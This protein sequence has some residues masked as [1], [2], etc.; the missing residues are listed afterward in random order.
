MDYGRACARPPEQ[1]AQPA[2][3]RR[4]AS[5]W[6]DCHNF[7][8]AL[9]GPS[10]RTSL[11]S[12]PLC[13]IDLRSWPGQ[14]SMEVHG[15]SLSFGPTT[16]AP[17]HLAAGSED[18][19]RSKQ[20]PLSPRG[21]IRRRPSQIRFGSGRRPWPPRATPASTSPPPNR[22]RARDSSRPLALTRHHL[23]TAGALP[24]TFTERTDRFESR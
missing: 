3:D 18:T 2:P 1:V 14:A 24:L 19:D 7:S 6:S 10:G 17:A 5:H 8:G 20:C 23:T 4:M 22:H 12:R 21:H 16:P 11:S 15:L 9:D 13:F